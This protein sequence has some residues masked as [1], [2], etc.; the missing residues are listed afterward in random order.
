MKQEYKKKENENDEKLEEIQKKNL[1]AIRLVEDTIKEK[2]Q[3]LDEKTFCVKELE[4]ITQQLDAYKQMERNIKEK[5]QKN[6]IEIA[7]EIQKKENEKNIL[8]NKIDLL[9]KSQEELVQK[10]INLETELNQTKNR[11]H[12][13]EN[14]DKV[15]RKAKEKA[16]TDLELLQK[17]T[18]KEKLILKQQID[19]LNKSNEE[20]K[21]RT[22]GQE[23]IISEITTQINLNSK[24]LKLTEEN[25]FQLDQVE[26]QKNKTLVEQLKIQLE[27]QNSNIENLKKLLESLQPEDE[28]KSK[29]IQDQKQKLNDQEIELEKLRKKMKELEA[30]ENV[31]AQNSQGKDKKRNLGVKNLDIFAIQIQDDKL[32]EK[33]KNL[34]EKIYEKN[35]NFLNEKELAQRELDTLKELQ[36]QYEKN[37]ENERNDLIEE[38]LKK[39]HKIKELIGEHQK[40]ESSLNQ[41]IEQL[42][43]L[44]EEK[45]S[46]IDTRDL[47]KTFEKQKE[48][49]ESMK[50]EYVSLVAQI[51]SNSYN[52]QQ[53]TYQ[54]KIK[55]LKKR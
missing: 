31:G 35:Q 34:Y 41:Q 43:N 1:S 19:D 53:K 5:D 13:L 54:N 29:E 47:E 23:K 42:K 18:Q 48:E 15:V 2:N 30:T 4:K 25:L 16:I 10:N 21:N 49:Y 52:Q 38:M 55:K 9:T 26:K 17:L 22:I 20:L 27:L 51:P 24:A 11:I 39:E 7:E 44:V 28:K 36:K 50:K 46:K 37:R 8:L 32:K 14:D 33:M 45:Q 40:K 12:L 6:T 3:L